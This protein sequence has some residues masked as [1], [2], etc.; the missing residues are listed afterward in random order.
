[1]AI[2]AGN[3]LAR[4]CGGSAETPCHSLPSGNSPRMPSLR[5]DP[6]HH[7]IC[8]LLPGDRIYA[9][10]AAAALHESHG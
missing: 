6:H 5:S 8:L 4:G 7:E 2:L 10:M 3:S 1:M 9:V